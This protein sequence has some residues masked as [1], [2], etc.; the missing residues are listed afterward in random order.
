MGE[1]GS[2]VRAALQS[3]SALCF[4]AKLPTNPLP[5]SLTPSSLAVQALL[6]Y[7]ARPKREPA[8]HN[9]VFLRDGPSTA[10]EEGA[11]L[12]KEKSQECVRMNEPRA[13]C[14]K[15][16]R[17]GYFYLRRVSLFSSERTLIQKGRGRG[18]ASSGDR[19]SHRL[20]EKFS[21]R[22]VQPGSVSRTA[23]VQSAATITAPLRSLQ[24][25]CS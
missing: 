12:G 10:G 18:E 25:A 7:K 24:L 2:C 20:E 19:S 14:G 3:R 8:R 23:D 21:R 1:S 22:R 11:R 13:R 4:L 16:G 17:W 9:G 6:N 5:Q 15:H